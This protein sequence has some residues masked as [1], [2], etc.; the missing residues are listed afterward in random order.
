MTASLSRIRH[1][2]FD[3]DGTLYLGEAVLDGTLDLLARLRATGRSYA[4]V[5]NNSSRSTRDVEAKVAKL[6]M[7]V[8]GGCVI[9]SGGA[10][11][12]Y[13]RDRLHATRA[14]VLGTPSLE[15]EVREGGIAL[16]AGRPE[17]VLLGMD[18]TLTYEKLSRATHLIRGG[19]PFVATHPDLLCPSPEG[20]IPDCGSLSASLAAATGVEP[21][22]IGKPYE[23]M[24]HIAL[25][26]LGARPDT[27]AIVGDR[28]YTDIE[29]GFRG[30]LMT[31]L[32]LTGEG[33]REL[34]REYHR[35]PDLI[36]PSPRDL[37]ALIE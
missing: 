10:A 31:I 32:V 17:A 28:L 19:V 7:A 6:G 21:T 20:P 12:E 29:M 15:A 13:L 26:R 27:T 34:A 30:G 18:M 11:V 25:G 8:P 5:T 3:L 23:A 33:T 2:L 36:V 35:S 22:V 9:T 37:A 14:Y 24:L 4:Y 16:D 1:F